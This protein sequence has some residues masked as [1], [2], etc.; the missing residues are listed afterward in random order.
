MSKNNQPPQP[1]KAPQITI[2]PEPLA[3][4]EGTPPTP[5]EVNIITAASQ[6]VTHKVLQTPDW[7]LPDCGRRL[8]ETVAQL[9]MSMPYSDV[10]TLIDGYIRF[11]SPAFKTDGDTNFPRPV[12]F[13]PRGNELSQDR[14]FPLL[15]CFDV[16]RSLLLYYKAVREEKVSPE[17]VRAIVKLEDISK[18]PHQYRVFGN[19]ADGYHIQRETL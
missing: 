13:H 8:R 5:E 14:S 9:G 17:L 3:V 19:D 6:A 2:K 15:V 4:D 11:C 7:S 16:G 18:N 10:R 1:P 12:K